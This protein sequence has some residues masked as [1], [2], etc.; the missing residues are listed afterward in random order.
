MSYQIKSTP[1]FRR[2]FNNSKKNGQLQRLREEYERIQEFNDRTIELKMRQVRLK[3]LFR[4]IEEI[5]D[6]GAGGGNNNSNN[7]GNNAANIGGGGAGGAAIAQSGRDH[8]RA[9]SR[10][11]SCSSARGR[12]MRRRHHRMMAVTTP[13]QRRHHQRVEA[14]TRAR[15]LG[16]E[17]SRRNAEIAET[18]CGGYLRNELRVTAKMQAV[19]DARREAVERRERAAKRISYGNDQSRQ[20]LLR[21]LQV[22]QKRLMGGHS[23]M[24]L[25]QQSSHPAQ[26]GPSRAHTHI[27]QGHA[28]SI[29]HAQL[30][31]PRPSRQKHSSSRYLNR[32]PDFRQMTDS[33]LDFLAN[34]ARE[35]QQQRVRRDHNGTYNKG[36]SDDV[37]DEDINTDELEQLGLEEERIRRQMNYSEEE[38]FRQDREYSDD[39]LLQK[40]TSDEP[41]E[42]DGEEE[43][44]SQGEERNDGGREEVSGEQPLNGKRVRKTALE[45]ELQLRQ[46]VQQEDEAEEAEEQ[47]RRMH[48]REETSP[49]RMTRFS[50]SSTTTT[51]TAATPGCNHAPQRDDNPTE[52]SDND[53]VTVPSHSATIAAH[54]PSCFVPRNASW[55]EQAENNDDVE[56]DDNDDDDEDDDENEGKE[57]EEQEQEQEQV[58]KHRFQIDAGVDPM[59]S[60]NHWRRIALMLPF[61]NASHHL[62]AK[63]T[64][65][66]AV[67]EELDE[68]G[69]PN[70]SCMCSYHSTPTMEIHQH[71]YQQQSLFQLQQEQPQPHH[72]HHYHQP[73]HHIQQH[74]RQT[75]VYRSPHSEYLMSTFQCMD[76]VEL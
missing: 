73:Q 26:V 40:Q 70:M 38:R 52:D 22:R 45:Q 74:Q 30:T 3:R 32:Y 8:S 67:I 33:Q 14:L 65:E 43:E 15:E 71:Q 66:S 39:G 44:E 36:H 17:I 23:P 16:K 2:M 62:K 55:P 59:P 63:T 48:L 5:K 9:R 76:A 31:A 57:D 61:I 7:N 35:E 56:V 60:I 10:G 46:Q 28:Q 41:T 53:M 21:Q 49:L 12:V 29:S 20:N 37:A 18:G 69:A 72:H 50:L 58:D 19:Q 1:Y 4:E 51:A 47:R 42:L 25:A 11:G 24:H 64:T 6:G 34:Q 75:T 27:H 54:Q 68:D 13:E